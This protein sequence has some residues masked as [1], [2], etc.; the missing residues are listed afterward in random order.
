MALFEL[1][2][3]LLFVGALFAL[4]ADR[5]GVP[6]P[7]LLA[8]VGAAIAF[9]PG[10]P[11]LAL[12]PELALSLF[13]APTLLDAAYDASP[14]DLRRNL[15]P[16][17][18]LALVLVLV[19]VASVAWVLRLTVPGVGWA[20]AI[21]LGAIV[22]P[23]D[24]S[25][26]TAV[27]SKLRPPHRLLVILEGES[28]FNDASAL[29]VYRVAVAAAMTG[30][31][32]GWSVIPTLVL[33]CGGGVVAGWVFARV[34]LRATSRVD[35]I[36]INVLLQFIA[37]FAVW[38]IAERLGLSAIITVVAFAMTLARR[39]G[40]RMNARH[41]IA[42][43]AVWEVAVLVLNVLAFVLIGL[44]LRAVVVRIHGAERGTYAAAGAAVCAAVIVVRVAW[45][46]L[47]GAV[48]HR[49]GRRDPSTRAEQPSYASG[50]VA[51]WCGMRGIV[52]LAAALA[53]PSGE[54]AFPHRD[55][56]VFCAFCVVL[57]TL[58]VQGMTLRP[59]MAHL[60]LGA[61]DTVEREVALARA[62]TAQAAL[63]VLQR[64]P[65]D[66]HA[67]Q[68]LRSE[69]QARLEHGASGRP[70]AAEDEDLA[71]LQRQVVAA[72]RNALTDLRAR[73]VVGDAAL[74]VVEEEIDLLELTA[75][76][77]VPPAVAPSAG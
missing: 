7:A 34:H 5:I 53:L 76:A 35:D 30:A 4:W 8:L 43:Y 69:Y 49:L 73:H 41:R 44:Q 24:A 18:S 68:Q 22:A 17:L 55:I 65:A 23:P 11:E 59:L 77:S 28:L 2:V 74:H 33:T 42:S 47:H 10:V 64:A 50:L 62:A 6:Y 61:D 56:I 57:T 36:P 75:D 52:T 72:Q 1:V 14:R 60:R 38:M 25:A 16:V 15:A 67:A 71:A 26:A 40:G 27:L 63:D 39:L 48:A 32:S 70:S 31:F 58:V 51:S 54:I 19:T 66:S 45:I 9:L 20:A 13:V 46:M 37:T 21:A 12:D 3:A 29:L